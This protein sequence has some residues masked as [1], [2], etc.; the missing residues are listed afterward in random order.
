MAI[1]A[2]PADSSSRPGIDYSTPE[3]GFRRALIL[4]G[5]KRMDQSRAENDG[6]DTAE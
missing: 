2:S 3:Q 6:A 1:L 4:H 5:A